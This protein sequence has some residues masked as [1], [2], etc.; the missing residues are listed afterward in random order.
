MSRYWPSRKRVNEI[1]LVDW[2][3]AAG[4]EDST[5]E[6]ALLMFPARKPFQ[7]SLHA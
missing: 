6:S 2:N 1:K 4:Y 3:L 5:F 7:M